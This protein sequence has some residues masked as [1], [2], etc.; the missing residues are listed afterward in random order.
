MHR[1]YLLYMPAFFDSGPNEYC[2]VKKFLKIARIPGYDKTV[3][4][5]LLVDRLKIIESEWDK[6]FKLKP[7][8]LILASPCGKQY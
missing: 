2:K 1:C 7:N 3:C 4:T 8:S 5:R 6:W